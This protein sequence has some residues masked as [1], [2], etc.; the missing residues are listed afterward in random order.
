MTNK[1]LQESLAEYDDDLK[2]EVTRVIAADLEVEGD[3]DL[4]QVRLD[5][6]IVGLAD[7]GDGDLLFVINSGGKDVHKHLA[8]L[9]EVKPLGDVDVV[10]TEETEGK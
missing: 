7:K 4:Y 2:V 1:E 10:E 9:G 6:P 3:P 8:T 5:W